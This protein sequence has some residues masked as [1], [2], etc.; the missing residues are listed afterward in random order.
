L[1]RI[2]LHVIAGLVAACLLVYAGDFL[3]LEVRAHMGH[4]FGT[5]KVSP[6]YAIPQKNG[7]SEFVFGQPENQQCVRSLFP[8][9]GDT[10]CWYLN[11]NANNPVQM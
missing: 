1:K 11:R 2:M 5:V 7:S 10:P 4:A 8:H 9:F 3:V 6:T